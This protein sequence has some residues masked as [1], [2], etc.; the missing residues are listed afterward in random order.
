MKSSLWINGF[1]LGLPQNI[2]PH[3]I[4]PTNFAPATLTITLTLT[5]TITMLSVVEQ[6]V[7][8]A[9]FLGYSALGQGVLGQEVGHQ[10]MHQKVLNLQESIDS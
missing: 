8:G 7:T 3:N 5:L 10:L 6:D 1:P 4:F 9:K 2:V